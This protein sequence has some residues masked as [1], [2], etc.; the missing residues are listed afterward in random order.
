[1]AMWSLAL[2][3]GLRA[4]GFLLLLVAG[5]AGTPTASLAQYG[6]KVAIPNGVVFGS[7]K[8]ACDALSHWHRGTTAVAFR[9][10]PD[11]ANGIYYVHCGYAFNGLEEAAG[12][13]GFY[14]WTQL[15]CSPGNKAAFEG[16]RPYVE[17]AAPA[18]QRCSCQASTSPCSDGAQSSKSDEPGNASGAVCSSDASRGNPVAISTGRKYDAFTDYQSGGTNPLVL[19]RYYNSAGLRPSAAGPG[20]LLDLII[21]M[22]PAWSISFDRWI[23]VYSK[24]NPTTVFV[25]RED[26]SYLKFTKSGSVWV[27]ASPAANVAPVPGTIEQFTFTDEDGRVDT[28]QLSIHAGGP[29]GR[30]IS[31]VFRNGYAQN[32]TY[33]PSTGRLT[34]VTDSYGRTLTFTWTNGV[35][36]RVDAPGGVVLEYSYDRI[37]GPI[38][39][40]IGSDRL[41]GFTRRASDGTQVE[42][43]TY[44]YE[45]EDADNNLR[46]ALTGITDERGNRLA[47]YTYDAYSRVIAETH[48]GGANQMTV[49]FNDAATTRTVTNAL[50]KQSI[51]RYSLRNSR[52]MLDRIDGQASTNVP[53]A[54]YILAYNAAGHITSRTDWRG[55]VTSYVRDAIGLETSRT[56]ASGTPQ[57]R[58]ITTTWDT[59]KRLPTQ[60]TWPGRRIDFAYDTQ[61]RLLTRTETDT[62]TQAVPYSTNGRTRVW[63][64]TYDA[65][66]QVTSV[67]GP[68]IDV[69]DVTTYAYTNGNLT[70]V[71]NAL[72]QVTNITAHNGRGLPTTIVDANNVTTNLSYDVHGRLTS[73]T[74]VAGGG[75]AT[76]TIAY[77]AAGLV[78]RITRPNGS[79]L[80]FTYDQAQRLT[81]IANN[82]GETITY[83]LDAL[84]NRTQT[85][86]KDAAAAVIRTRSAVFD[87][88]SRLLQSIG[89]A[90]QTTTYA[91]DHN[92]NVITVTDPLTRQTGQAYDAL[93]RL[94]Q[95]TD[96]LS[97]AAVNTYDARD[98]LLTVKDER[99]L[100][101]THVYDGLNN[102]IQ[103]ASPD[104][105]TT[106]YEYDAAGN[107]TRETDARGVITDFTYDALDRVTAKSFLGASPENV[108]YS[109][110]A[111]AGDNKGVGRL[112]GI[113]DPS[114]STA[115]T[116][117]ER[118]NV[119]S[120]ARAIGGQSYTTS[121]AYDL[122][123]NVTQIVYPSG[124]IVD[125]SYD[126][127]GRIAGVTTKANAGAAAETV[128]SS[129]AYQPF[130]PL[131]GL[132][133][134]NGLSLV[135]SFDNDGRI[136]SHRVSF[137][138]QD[139]QNLSYGYDTASN[140][141]TITD[142]VNAARSESFGY[143]QLY[144]LVSA[145]GAYGYLTWSYDAVGNRTNQ[146]LSGA[147]GFSELYSY[148][149][150]S[151]RLLSVVR[152]ADTRS[153]TY[154]PSGQ[155]S[156]D[157]RN[158]SQD[159]TLGYDAT[160][161][162]KQLDNLA[163]PVA[164]Y[165]HNALGERVLKSLPSNRA[166][167][168]DSD[169]KLLQEYTTPVTTT[170]VAHIW[171]GDLPLAVEQSG[172]LYY[173]HPDHRGTTLRITDGAQALKW[174]AILTPFGE[175]HSLPAQALSYSPRLPGQFLDTEGNTGWLQNYFRT[176]DPTIG[177]YVQSDP[178]GLRGGLNTFAY[179]NANP[180]AHVD[181]DGLSAT[182]ASPDDVRLSYLL[183]RLYNR[184]TAPGVC[185]VTGP[186]APLPPYAVQGAQNGSSVGPQ[187]GRETADEPERCRKVI[188][189]CRDRCSQTF[190]DN[191]DDLPGIGP[192]M[193]GRIR[194]CIRECAKANGCSF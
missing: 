89:A 101:T 153:F 2:S 18:P 177:R 132:V 84:G 62:T 54:S 166:F 131:K 15:V 192:D 28:F 183:F 91:Y 59:A 8:A 25:Y 193:A 141:T 12:I 149:T 53:A 190:A 186:L 98:N 83:T 45:Q 148:A 142:T 133:Y 73:Y 38:G 152:G 87:E 121:Y 80:D 154:L 130:G 100:T 179:V 164:T 168:F 47:T 143:D 160:G 113:A 194:W 140:I 63:T 93:N 180:V 21:P 46:Y 76:T 1:M 116:Y 145:S 162:F 74:V 176:Y 147:G 92:S 49:S 167:H 65:T 127:L 39:P 78:T 30:L 151:N 103:I 20:N 189:Q 175:T 32:F 95:V 119:I 34:T 104:T 156:R 3:G 33:N 112:T 37:Q 67:D 52:Y 31:S 50:G 171:L 172:N 105:G 125:Y 51:Y 57:A 66:G 23:Q 19:A 55:I 155:V 108:T 88:L 174:D 161:R 77:D 184:V 48:A 60:I 56:E 136:A 188:N 26:G 16:C 70:S 14:G 114:G 117:D 61:G 4:V 178:V 72:S 6:W 29:R 120:D 94:T 137:G 170:P 85:H 99:N 187:A 182:L 58:T 10:D 41:I 135:R 139:T 128:A 157:N 64:Y 97:G 86:V 17:P 107:R 150:D 40:M 35:I 181:R 44:H 82:A 90:S 43:Q 191:P 158:G 118:G 71:T 185:P 124:R 11:I 68:R 115:F 75:N 27:S 42:S 165:Q 126:S 69:S 144:R 36:S 123:D 81:Q 159:F 96:A 9:H 111:T 22:G 122:A 173:T 79:Y 13:Y 109:Y 110:D 102:L 5:I 163:S 169:G 7:Y 138:A 106:V 134:G 24:S 129:V 146:S